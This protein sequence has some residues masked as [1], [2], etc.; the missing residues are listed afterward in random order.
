MGSLPT[1]ELC[2]IISKLLVCRSIREKVWAKVGGVV[3]CPVVP[4]GAVCQC[5]LLLSQGLT[6]DLGMMLSITQA[7]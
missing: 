4:C 2:D 7:A 6:E 5:G 1:Q 3:T